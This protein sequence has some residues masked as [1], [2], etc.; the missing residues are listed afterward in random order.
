MKPLTSCSDPETPC[1]EL[2]TT[3]A[4]QNL[5]G[6]NDLGCVKRLEG[7]GLA[8]QTFEGVSIHDGSVKSPISLPMLQALM[9][10]SWPHIVALNKSGDMMSIPPP[11]GAT[12]MIIVGRNGSWQ[13]S[14]IPVSSC[15][16]IDN[17]CTDCDPEWIAGLK[18]TIDPETD[19]VSGV[20]LT[21]IAPGQIAGLTGEYWINTATVLLEGAGTQASPRGAHVEISPDPG[22]ILEAR[23][24]GLFVGCCALQYEGFY[25]Q[26]NEWSLFTFD[27][28][29]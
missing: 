21:R 25:D 13:I 4:A 19:E 26:Y 27:P 15:F 14:E 12:P 23:S 10:A 6:I 9:G 22:N 8:V 3:D 16:P 29:I 5:A 24:N 20:C 7:E 11:T 17:V 28:V 1:T 2:G 18:N